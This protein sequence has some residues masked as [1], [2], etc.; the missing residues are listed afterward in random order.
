MSRS[1]IQPRKD[2]NQTLERER[3]NLSK[4]KIDKDFP[5]YFFHLKHSIQSTLYAQKIDI[6]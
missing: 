2:S 5:K 6:V 4:L 3:K 1:G